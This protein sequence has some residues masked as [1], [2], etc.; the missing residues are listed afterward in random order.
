MLVSKFSAAAGKQ[1]VM[2]QS[3]YKLQRGADSPFLASTEGKRTSAASLPSVKRL[4]CRINQSVWLP[5]DIRASA[6]T[7]CSFRWK[8]NLGL[9]LLVVKKKPSKLFQ[10]VLTNTVL[11]SESAF[12]RALE[13]LRDSKHEPSVFHLNYPMGHRNSQSNISTG[14]Y[15]G[16]REHQQVGAECCSCGKWPR[17]RRE[18][19]CQRK[20]GRKLKSLNSIDLMMNLSFHMERLNTFNFKF[21]ILRQMTNTGRIFFCP[22]GSLPFNRFMPMMIMFNPEI[23][24]LFVMFPMSFMEMPLCSTESVGLLICNPAHS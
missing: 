2:E 4:A 21:V 20:I 6:E 23:D 5:E 16:S 12:F 24:C 11:P 10:V 17:Q 14:G 9:P 22:L 3:S 18:K 7:R 13:H 8:T 1:G 15:E 19:V